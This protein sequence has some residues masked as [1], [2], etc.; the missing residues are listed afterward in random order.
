MKH[1]VERRTGF[2]KGLGT[3]LAFALPGLA[4]ADFGLDVSPDYYAVDTGAGLTFKVRRTDWGTLSEGDIVS[5]NYRGTEYHSR[6]RGSHVNAGFDWL[7]NGVTEV[8]VDAAVYGDD[9]IK[10]TVRAGD[11]THYYMARRGYPHIYMATHFAR[12]PDIHNHVRYITRLDSD[13]V[14]YGPEPSDIRN[15]VSTVEAGDIFALANGET[16]SKHYSN[17]RLKD[18]SYIGATGGNVGMWIVRDGQ[19]GGSGGPFYRSLL[20]Q[21]TDTEQ[22]LTYIVNYGEA[23]TEDF[24]PGILNSYTLVATDGSAPDT[25]PDTA[26]FEQMDL[27]GYIPASDRGLVAG[28]GLSGMDNR[29]DYTVG[30]DNEKAQYWVDASNGFYKSAGMIPGDYTMKVY[31]NELVVH[32]RDISVT[33]GGQTLLN[34]ISI[35][36]DPSVDTAI[37]RIGDWD[38]TPLEMLNGDKLTRMHPSDIRI[39]TWNP[40]EFT[41]GNNSAA[42]F[43]AYIWQDINNDQVVYFRLSDQERAT[44]HTLR[45][46]LTCAFANGRP[47]IHVNGWSSS[48][49]D[50]SEQP[51]TRTMTVG[52]YRC[53]NVTYDFDIP[54]H[55]WKSGSND[56]NKLT[57]SVI[58]GS[59]AGEYLSAGVSIDSIDLLR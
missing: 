54:A 9:Y 51:K 21:A 32:E 47:R 28:V 38:G 8:D 36:D 25:H 14:P 42:D 13:M 53:N 56:L 27:Q 45:V 59:G 44:A 16:R 12:E 55:V 7:Y 2:L 26:W 19:E 15:T 57:L 34:T 46:G 20:N 22:Q 6:L 37:W 41:V 17:Q 29:Y 23:Q 52:T 50:P 35:N 31:K 43:P 40:G 49:R 3:V 58:S 10:L 5:I 1:C 4:M 30:F 33:A 39:E 18:W 24:R 11:L 48:F